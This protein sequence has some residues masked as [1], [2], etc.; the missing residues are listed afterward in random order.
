MSQVTRSFSA[1]V[2]FQESI[3]LIVCDFLFYIIKFHKIFLFY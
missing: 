3:R 1:P 2:E